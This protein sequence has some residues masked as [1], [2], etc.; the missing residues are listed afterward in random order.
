MEEWEAGRKMTDDS[1]RDARVDTVL[2]ALRSFQTRVSP[3]FMDR[4]A[5]RINLQPC[6]EG[7]PVGR[8]ASRLFTQ[9]ANLALSIL[10]RD[11]P[12][13]PEDE[14]ENEAENDQG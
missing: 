6:Q 11:H 9:I 7:P 8:M 1:E 12:E 2:E 3:D 13:P 10:H 4:R 5:A 14:A